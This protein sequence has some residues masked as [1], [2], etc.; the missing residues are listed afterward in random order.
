MQKL[1]FL[2]R[3][4]EYQRQSKNKFDI[5]P[6]FLFDLVTKVF[7]DKKSYPE[8][9]IVENIKK[10][11]LASK[12]TISVSDFGAGSVVDRGSERS[13]SRITKHSSKPAKYGRLLFRLAS[14]FKPS[15]ILEL[16][17]SVGLS[18][19]YMALGNLNAKITTIEGCPNISALA[20]TN[21]NKAGIENIRLIT[22]NFDQMLPDVLKTMPQI[23]LVFIDGN[24]RH[25]P[26]INY[27][28]QCIENSVNDTCIIFDDIHWSEEMEQ[29]WHNI[30][31]HE[32][33]TLSID[34]F[35]M[36]LVFFKKELTKQHFTVRF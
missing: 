33:V 5:H 25:E 4:V 27:F 34:I 3:Y 13:V 10:E 36:G 24:H 9:L 16:G 2:L 32:A 29:A 19:C 12:K 6:P 23:D 20:K 21:F 7:E 18:S 17:T 28:E 1:K 8:Y 15:N 31:D 14:Y 26:T 30:I 22:G 11:L 35:F